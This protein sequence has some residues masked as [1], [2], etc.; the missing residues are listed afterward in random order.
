MIKSLS[1]V[2]CLV[3]LPFS[4]GQAFAYTIEGGVEHVERM[5]AVAPE[6]RAGAEFNSETLKTSS[7]N[8]W[9]R[10]PAFLAGTWLVKNETAV[11]RKDFK[12]GKIY[13]SPLTYKARHEFSYGHQQDPQGGIWHYVGVPYTSE[14]RSSDYI[15]YHKVSRKDFQVLTDS[16]VRFRC[17]MNV[18]RVSHYDDDRISGSF[19]QESITS[20]R[21]LEEGTIELTSSTKSFDQAGLPSFE[22]CNNAVIKRSKPFKPVAEKDGKDLKALFIEF[23]T[24]TGKSNLL[25]D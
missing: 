1:I 23:L 3:L 9:I 16:E 22:T 19:Q 20:Y 24:A 2:A 5:P 7:G 6:L 14:T 13:Q 21:P 8:N 18:V 10:V 15:E 17:L 25:P 4:L 12:T 11:Y